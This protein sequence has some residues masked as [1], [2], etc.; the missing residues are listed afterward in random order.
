MIATRHSGSPIR[1]PGRRQTGKPRCRAHEL[2]CIRGD[3]ADD[4]CDARLRLR[5]LPPCCQCSLA[6]SARHA[7]RPPVPECPDR[8]CGLSVFVERDCAD[9]G[10]RAGILRRGTLQPWPPGRSRLPS[11]EVDRLGFGAMRITGDGVWGPPRDHDEAIRVL[12]RAVEL[13]VTLID[14][15]DSYGPNVSE[16]LIAEALFRT[17]A[18]WWSPRRAA[19][20]GPRGKLGRRRPPGASP[21]G[22]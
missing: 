7:R 6:D 14:T 9:D 1:A 22:V 12:R 20:S 5:P 16:E 15:A 13:G 18:G 10:W 17:R 21:S 4:R 8:C 19:R 2:R 11:L 3:G